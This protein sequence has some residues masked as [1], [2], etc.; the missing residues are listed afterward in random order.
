M[1]FRKSIKLAPGIRLNASTRGASVSLGGRGA[2]W[3]VSLRGVRTTVSIPGTGVSWSRQLSGRARSRP[4]SRRASPRPSGAAGQAII[5]AEDAALREVVEQWR[6]TPPIPGLGAFKAACQ[7]QPYEHPE[8]PPRPVDL[9]QLASRERS[10][11]LAQARRDAKAPSILEAIGVGVA[12]A[13]V[14][15]AVTLLAWLATGSPAALVA[16]TGGAVLASATA[17]VMV[18]AVSTARSRAAIEARVD[19]QLAQRWN[20]VQVAANRRYLTMLSQ[21]ETR[22]SG[23]ENTWNEEERRRVAWVQRL[24]RGEPDAVEAALEAALEQLDFPF[25]TEAAISVSSDG[26]AFL[27]VDLPEIED[28]IPD[29]RTKVLKSG[30]VRSAK[31]SA[32]DRQDAYARLTCG[33]VLQLA[34]AA[35]SV[36]PWIGEVH[37]AAYTQ[38]RVAKTGALRDEYVIELVA[39]LSPRSVP[40]LVPA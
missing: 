39:C 6:D 33:L 31:R 36:S 20:E 16:L 28:V 27:L 9:A 8:P 23:E 30:A 1:R 34:A 14:G 4:P 10:K 11:L 17:G 21:F 13:A 18:G 19:E 38:R 32:A 12:V 35:F 40:A 24:I 7:H 3:N 2:T 15:G 29:E 25:E 5:A 22:R 26:G 37:V